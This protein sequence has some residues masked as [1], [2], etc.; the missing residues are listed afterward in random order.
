MSCGSSIPLLPCR[1]SVVAVLMLLVSRVHISAAIEG[2]WESSLEELEEAAIEAAQCNCVR[3]FSRMESSE[4]LTCVWQMEERLRLVLSIGDRSRKALTCSKQRRLEVALADAWYGCEF[5]LIDPNHPIYSERYSA[6]LEPFPG[7]DVGGTGSNSKKGRPSKTTFYLRDVVKPR[8]PVALSLR[9]LQHNGG[10]ELSWKTRY[11]KSDFIT[12]RLKFQV[13][14]SRRPDGHWKTTDVGENHKRHFSKQELL[15][16]HRY[17]FRVRAK[18]SG[19]Y[20]NGSWSSWSSVLEKT[21]S[22][23]SCPDALS[24]D[25]ASMDGFELTWRSFQFNGGSTHKPGD[26]GRMPRLPDGP[27][28]SSPAN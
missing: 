13:N 22:E 4:V 9:P 11:T 8:V 16:G 19:S 25:Q 28:Q 6:I 5:Q 27:A 20:F 10:F 1:I 2:P 24:Y 21:F 12:S 15:R 14:S 23:A 17:A 7:T 3:C 18:T 26:W